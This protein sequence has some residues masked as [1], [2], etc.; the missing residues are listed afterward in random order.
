M[1]LLRIR[2]ITEKGFVSWAIRSATFSEFSHAEIVS[3][4]QKSYIGARS[5]GGVQERAAN[6]CVPSFERRYAI[7]C[8]DAQ[9]AKIMTYAR[10]MIG[11]PYNFKDII[12]LLFHHN[13]A[14]KGTFICS[15]FV[16]LAAWEGGI[17]LLNVLPN[18]ANLVTPDTLHLSPLLIGNCYYSAGKP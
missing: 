15:M 3:E 13:T 14:T 10:S 2:F 9:L 7:L 6:Y 8:T 18:Y 4:D 17:D 16:F 1:A 11:T 5:S 12:G